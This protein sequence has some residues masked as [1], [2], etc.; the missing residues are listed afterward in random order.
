[1]AASPGDIISSFDFPARI[2]NELLELLG[3]ALQGRTGP[4]I[5]NAVQQL[6]Y[7]FR[8]DYRT[9]HRA[10]WVRVFGVITRYPSRLETVTD[11]VST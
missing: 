9:G 1:M 4:H 10:W 2:T 11:T 5:D 7:I 8:F 3:N 6:V